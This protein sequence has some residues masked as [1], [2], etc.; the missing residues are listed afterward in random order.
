MREPGYYWCKGN[1]CY[2]EQDMKW[3]ILFWDGHFFW[4]DGNDF[5]DDVFLKIDEIRLLPPEIE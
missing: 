1:S 5:S 3:R 2:V 4:D